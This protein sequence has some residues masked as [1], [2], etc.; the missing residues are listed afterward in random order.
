MLHTALS[1]G[2]SFGADRFVT[3][4][5]LCYMS[6][7]NLDLYLTIFCAATLYFAPPSARHDMR[8]RLSTV[9]Q[10]NPTLFFGTTRYDY[11]FVVKIDDSCLFHMYIVHGNK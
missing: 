11:N 10:V 1:P 4:N 9:R 8:E 3:C 7:L 2:L 6:C 5:A